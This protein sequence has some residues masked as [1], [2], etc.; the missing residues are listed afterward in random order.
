MDIVLIGSG[1]VAH[2]LGAALKKAGHRIVQ[3]YSPT[4]EHARRLA[5]FL[6]SEATQSLHDLRSDA[7][8]YILAVRDQAIPEVVQ[9]L[10]LSWQGTVVHTSGATSIDLLDKWS[11]YGVIYPPQSLSKEVPTDLSLIPFAI[12]GNKEA[13]KDFLF[14]TIHPIAPLSFEANSTQRLA[15]HIAAV[16]ANNFSNALYKIAFDILS[17]QNLPVDVIRPIILESAMKVQNRLPQQVQTGPARRND[18]LT[19]E[20]HLEYLKLEPDWQTIY[21]IMSQFIKKSEI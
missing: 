1:N 11:K 12:E 13:V 15:L 9:Q 14:T 19:M 2:H 7:D 17:D 16:F 20:K 10:P 8:L 6:Q 21:Q 3:V 18:T 4:A 5:D